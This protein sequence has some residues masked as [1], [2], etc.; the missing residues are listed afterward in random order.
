[1]DRT[2]DWRRTGT[3]APSLAAEEPWPTLSQF[4]EALYDSQLLTP[5]NARVLLKDYPGLSEGDAPLL[6]RALTARGLLTEYQVERLRAGQT[7]GLVL[8]NYRIVD[9]LGAGGMGVVF[10]AEHVHMKRPV[11][12]KVVL[13]ENE[14]NNVFLERFTSE[15]QVLAG[16]NHP[17]IVLAFD[18]GEVDVPG[19]KGHVLRYLVMEY[20]SGRDLEVYVE[21]RGPL[22]IPLACE[23]VRQTALGLQHAHER[24]LVHRDIK[25]SNLLLTTPAVLE[26]TNAG[27]GQQ[28]PQVK[29]LDFGLARLCRRRCT[30]AKVTLGTVDYMAPEQARDARSVDIRADV[31]SLGGTLFWLLTGQRP[32]NSDRAVIEELLARQHESPPSVRGLRRDI[33]LELDAIVSQMMARDPNDRYQTPLAV[34]TALDDFLEPSVLAAAHAGAEVQANGDS[35]PDTL[36]SSG[37][38]IDVALH[39]GRSHRVL[40]LSP[41]P[42]TILACRGL[43]ERHGLTCFD[44]RRESEVREVLAGNP[45]DVVLVDARLA[46]P[47]GHDI[48][49]RLRAGAGIPNLKMIL[50][51]P[52]EGPP[53]GVVENEPSCDDQ[54]QLSRLGDDLVT[55]VRLAVRLKGAEERSDRLAH[56]L[57]TTNAQL[58]Q[59]LQQR[60]AFTQQSQDVLIF[61]MARMAELRGRETPAHLIR[62]Q[63]YARIL[64]EE[65]MRLPAFARSIDSAFVRMLERCVPLHDIGK[66]ALPDHILLKP[67]PLEPEERSIMESHTLLGAEMLEAVAR[68]QG[69]CLAFLEMAIDVVRHHHERYDGTGYPDGLAGDAIPLAARI[70][71][72]ADV[73]DAMRC[74][75]VYKPGLPHAAVR[76]IL[77][78][79]TQSQFDPALMV[80]FRQCESFFEQIFA[81]NGD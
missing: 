76:R 26:N 18:A 68:Q 23:L 11:A 60:D 36:L 52:D 25:P 47:N 16:L 30:E 44:A 41:R 6:A 58:E 3:L 34:I 66:V 53:C 33:P 31:Y 5:Q 9:W 24:G 19:H 81:R 67:G 37:N 14:G 22:P 21:E 1:M 27:S 12:V 45:C 78:N 42:E 29:I 77:L 69:A 35:L 61:A 74:R 56:S 50:L 75:L 40:I 72:V 10:K 20:V 59:V 51:V 73:Y 39:A 15:M 46:E 32:F 8:G 38:T 2:G 28:G 80:A 71:A 4:L 63:K 55:R 13:T 54:T 65:A 7:F 64:A 62:M 48:G 57:L 43:L 79:P 49:R 70:V 17:N